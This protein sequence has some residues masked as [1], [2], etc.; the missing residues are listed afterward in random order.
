M[1]VVVVRGG[2]V[3]GVVVCVLFLCGVSAADVVCAVLVLACALLVGV[4][5][6]VGCGVVLVVASCEGHMVDALASRADE[7]RWSLR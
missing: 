4:G 6:G 2:L 1:V 3:W 7:G 5:V